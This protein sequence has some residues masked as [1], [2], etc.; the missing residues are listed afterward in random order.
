MIFKVDPNAKKRRIEKF[1]ILC[2]ECELPNTNTLIKCY[3]NKI[4]FGCIYSKDID[5]IIEQFEKIIEKH[6]GPPPWVD[7]ID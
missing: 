5:S 7:L 2:E 6:E 4:L 1:K 3:E